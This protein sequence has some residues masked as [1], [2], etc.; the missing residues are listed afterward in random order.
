MSNLNDAPQE[1]LTRLPGLAARRG[2]RRAGV[3][4][5]V[6]PPLPNCD[7]RSAICFA[8]KQERSATRRQGMAD[9]DGGGE[10]GGPT[11]ALARLDGGLPV[12]RRHRQ[13]AGGI[14]SV[15]AGRLALDPAREYSKTPGYIAHA[16][17]RNGLLKR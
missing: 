5:L 13:C 12:S 3:R 17:A 10:R 11:G 6:F 16:G 7:T 14:G 4:G 9:R 15:A 2:L 8:Q 1:L